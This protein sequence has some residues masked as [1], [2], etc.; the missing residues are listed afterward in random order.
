[1]KIDLIICC[2][3]LIGLIEYQDVNFKDDVAQSTLLPLRATFAGV[4]K[5]WGENKDYD[6]WF[7]ELAAV[8]TTAFLPYSAYQEL[9]ESLSLGYEVDFFPPCSYDAPAFKALRDHNIKLVAAASL[10]YPDGDFPPIDQDPLRALLV[11]TGADMISAVYSMDEPAY[12]A[13]VDPEASIQQQVEALYQRVK[14]IN[15][16]LP[17]LMVHGPIPSE[18]QEVDGTFRP[19]TQP[20][21]DQ[22]L[23]SVKILS[24]YAD[25]IAFDLYPIPPEIGRFPVPGQ[26]IEGVDYTIAFP[27]YLEWLHKVAGDKPYFIVLQAFSFERQL[28][29]EIAQEAID[30]G[31]AV[32]PPTLAELQEMA[33]LAFEGGASEIGWWGQSFL[34]EADHLL[35][36]NVLNVTQN[37]TSDP[38]TYCNR[39]TSSLGSSRGRSV[40]NSQMAFASGSVANES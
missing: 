10:L 24:D 34:I 18:I 12:Q 38:V 20:E 17:V 6:A 4:P 5:Y 14:A 9:P 15:P 2:L 27:S 36:E 28:S 1:M 30:A 13:L 21:I 16:S 11:C 23:D 26:G 3:S 40:S 8:G 33:C 7:E 31:F 19:I 32:R 25:I 35:W 22:Y 37:M 29:A 39:R